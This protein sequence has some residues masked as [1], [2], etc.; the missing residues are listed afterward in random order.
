MFTLTFISSTGSTLVLRDHYHGTRV[1]NPP[2][3]QLLVALGPTLKELK[4]TGGIHDLAEARVSMSGLEVL[5]YGELDRH[6]AT[7]VPTVFPNIKKLCCRAPNDIRHLAGIRGC[8]NLKALSLSN[9]A[10]RFMYREMAGTLV[11]YVAMI[12]VAPLTELVCVPGLYEIV[13]DIETLI[14]RDQLD[15]IQV[16]VSLSSIPTS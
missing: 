4:L 8:H 6:E 7:L 16:S 5:T 15:G 10:T 13:P 11:H 3:V 14:I 9:I 2:V 12:R 1:V